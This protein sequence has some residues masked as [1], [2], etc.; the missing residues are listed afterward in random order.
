MK[1]VMDIERSATLVPDGSTLALGGLSMNSSPMA[2]VR[3]LI[4]QGKKNLTL[5]AIVNGMAVDWLAAEG[6]Q[7]TC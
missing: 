6:R 5:V 1:K 2:F 4:R 3:E 7:V